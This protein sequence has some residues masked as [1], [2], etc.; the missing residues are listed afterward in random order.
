MVNRACEDRY[1]AGIPSFIGGGADK[2]SLS[3]FIADMSGQTWFAA[4]YSAA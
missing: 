3:K 4:M 2:C 1:R